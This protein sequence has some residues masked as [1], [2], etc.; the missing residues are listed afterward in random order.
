MEDRG[1]YLQPGCQTRQLNQKGGAF[2]R[3]WADTVWQLVIGI[4]RLY[5]RRPADILGSSANDDIDRNKT[6]VGALQH[7]RRGGGVS[8]PGSTS[9]A[10]LPFWDSRS[11]SWSYLGFL[12]KAKD[13][14]DVDV[15]ETRADT[16]MQSVWAPAANSEERT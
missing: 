15:V 8:A 14:T 5:W 4:A 6:V 7:M 1:E 10:L 2:K 12:Q 9:G 3:A 16:W 13:A 11:S